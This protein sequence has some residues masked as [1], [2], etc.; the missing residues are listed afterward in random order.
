MRCGQIL[1]VSHPFTDDSAAKVRP[2]LVVSADQYN[3]GEDIIAVPI[4]SV[5]REDDPYTFPIRTTEAYFKQTG[6]RQG[7]HVK[8]TKPITISKIVVQ[9]RLGQLAS[10]PLTEIQAKIQ[11][12]FQ[13]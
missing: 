3:R 12:L 11:S 13:S 8:W 10:A 7:S 4:S 9:R 5:P 6:L 1:L 2:I